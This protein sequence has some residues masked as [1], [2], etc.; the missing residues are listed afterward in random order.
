LK[1]ILFVAVFVCGA[2]VG[3]IVW[4]WA[5]GGNDVAREV[6]RDQRAIP[7]FNIIDNSIVSQKNV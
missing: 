1:S 4:G 2:V 7:A 6:K 3:G 5:A